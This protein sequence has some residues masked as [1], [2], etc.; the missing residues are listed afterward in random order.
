MRAPVQE[1]QSVSL[2]PEAL[3]LYIGLR[4]Q[5]ISIENYVYTYLQSFRAPLTALLKIPVTYAMH[6]P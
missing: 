2:F 4:E 5:F 1:L 6:I 3:S